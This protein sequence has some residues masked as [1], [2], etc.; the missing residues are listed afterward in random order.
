M[1]KKEKRAKV[2]PIKQSN[3]YFIIE[4]EAF[5]YLL[6]ITISHNINNDYYRKIFRFQVNYLSQAN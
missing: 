5:M 3:V 4:W 2:R 1:K 6:E